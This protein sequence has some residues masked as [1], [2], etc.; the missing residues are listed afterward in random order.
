MDNTERAIVEID[1]QHGKGAIMRLGDDRAKLAIEAI[2]TGALSLDA[3]LGIGGVPRGRIIELSG[4]DS[5]GTTTQAWCSSARWMA[6]ASTATELT[7]FADGN[8]RRSL[9]VHAGARVIQQPVDTVQLIGR[10]TF[11]VGENHRAFAEFMGSEVESKRQFEA[12]QISSAAYPAG[13][14][15]Q[16]DISTVRTVFSGVA[17]LGTSIQAWAIVRNK[18]GFSKPSLLKSSRRSSSGRLP[19][20]PA[21]RQRSHLFS[22]NANAR[23]WRCS[24]N[25]SQPSRSWYFSCE[26]T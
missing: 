12:Q 3:A 6:A 19:I 5:T 23:R 24:M 26:P 4:P 7:V 9:L 15:D 1:R 2:P 10:A 13:T 14:A 25:K 18:C 22:T 8:P 16:F 11:K 20:A 17:P 21:C